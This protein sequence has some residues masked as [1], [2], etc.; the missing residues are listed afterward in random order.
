MAVFDLI[1]YELLIIF[2]I[3]NQFESLIQMQIAIYT[4]VPNN[5]LIL[6]Y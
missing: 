3:L 4:I 1:I 2:K 6:N 5:L